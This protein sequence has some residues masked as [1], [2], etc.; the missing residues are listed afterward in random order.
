MV[1][2]RPSGSNDNDRTISA[3]EESL[4]DARWRWRERRRRRRRTW[5]APHA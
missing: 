1:R 3:T 5:I 4:L 2:R